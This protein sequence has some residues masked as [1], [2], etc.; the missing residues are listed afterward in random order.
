MTTTPTL[1]FSMPEF[2][3]KKRNEIPLSQEE[4]FRFVQGACNGEIP[5][6]QTTAFLMATYFTGMSLDETAHLTR[7]MVESGE[8]WDLS[9]LKGAKIDKHSTGGVGDKVSIILG[10]LA[11]ACGL[12]VPMMAGRGLGHTGGTIDKLESI[13]GYR[14]ILSK[15]EF[16]HILGDVGCAIISQS[17]KIAPADR[18]FYALRDVTATIECI[19][20]I[21]SSILSKKIAEGTTGLVMDIKVGNGAF[22][23][24]KTEAIALAKT[25]RAVAK[26]AGIELRATLSNMDQP[27]GYAV[28]NAIEI[29]ECIEIMKNEKL[30]PYGLCS[31]DL[32]E[33]TLH[34]CAQMLEAG[35]V[36]KNLAEGR[37]LAIARLQDGSAWKKFKEMIKAQGGDSDSLEQPWLYLKS[38]KVVEIRCNKRGYVTEMKSEAIGRLLILLGGG[39]NKVGDPIDH[40]VGFIFHKKLGSQVKSD[41]TLVTV[42]GKTSTD[43]DFIERMLRSY[44]K[45]STTKKT[46]PKLILEANVR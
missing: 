32:K 2:I 36:V 21:T 1:P 7:A 37:K 34:L 28:G 14:A 5:D 31:V 35:K 26:K 27:L 15:D 20:L 17:E 46:A 38:E 40:T 25:M 12:K 9:K 44:I 8:T 45:I 22:M 30:N 3:Q 23:K 29:Y 16:V 18:K 11:A 13:R 33:L 41:D 43:F 6:Y 19:P 42:F 4:I 10:P 39:R 24:G